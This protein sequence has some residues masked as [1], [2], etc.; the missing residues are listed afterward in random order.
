MTAD[1]GALDGLAD[2]FTLLRKLE[3][4]SIY[5]GLSATRPGAVR[6][7]I[8]VPG[9]RWEVEFLDDGGVWVE[10]FRSS[11]SIEGQERL[12]DLFQRFSD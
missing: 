10:I 11:G 8:S 12:T 7:D 4:A 6:V 2:L 3:D 1:V 5:Y 9:E